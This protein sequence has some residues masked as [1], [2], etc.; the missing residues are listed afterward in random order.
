MRLDRSIRE[1]ADVAMG[2]EKRGRELTT[3]YEQLE[4]HVGTQIEEMRELAEVV[5]MRRKR[6]RSAQQAVERAEETEDPR[7]ALRR[8]SGLI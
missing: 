2:A 3:V 7:Q 6:V 1:I 4:A 5:N 8:Q